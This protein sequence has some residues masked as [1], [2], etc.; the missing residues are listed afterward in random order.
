MFSGSCS[1]SILPK[2]SQ[3]N[4][5]SNVNISNMFDDCIMLN[6]IPLLLIRTKSIDSNKTLQSSKSSKSSQSNKNNQSIIN[7]NL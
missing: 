1:I 3:W 2:I 7:I 5:P 4:L 6:N